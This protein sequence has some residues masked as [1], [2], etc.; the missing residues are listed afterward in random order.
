[1]H[2]PV[3]WAGR[4]PK[5]FFELCS[6]RPLEELNL[7]ITPVLVKVLLPWEEILEVWTDALHRREI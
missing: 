3:A 7:P 5:L 4:I 6:F 1:M 2:F